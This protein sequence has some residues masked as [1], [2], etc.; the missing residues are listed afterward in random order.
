MPNLL[1]LS[2]LSYSIKI[3]SSL[4]TSEF[5]TTIISQSINPSHMRSTT[6]AHCLIF[7]YIRQDLFYLLDYAG[8]SEIFQIG[9][10]KKKAWCNKLL[11]TA[12]SIFKGPF[13]DKLNQMT[14]DNYKS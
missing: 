3:K 10:R 13:F 1:N 9:D 11:C 8:P 2:N 12:V 5:E 6:V 4:N 14:L 7:V